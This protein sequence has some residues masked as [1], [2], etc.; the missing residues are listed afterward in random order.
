MCRYNQNIP[1]LGTPEG[2]AFRGRGRSSLSFPKKR[3]FFGK[4]AAP[5]LVRMSSLEA[6]SDEREEKIA[7]LA[8]RADAEADRRELNVSQPS[9]SRVLTRKLGGLMH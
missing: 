3:D 8:T 2:R 9:V 7:A 4:D 5:M 1:D 6:C